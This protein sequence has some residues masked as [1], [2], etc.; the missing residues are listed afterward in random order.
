MGAISGIRGKTYIRRRVIKTSAGIT[1]E[2]LNAC[3]N[4]AKKS[5]T[6]L[7]KVVIKY[8]V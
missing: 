4:V 3:T 6:L 7:T 1:D 2:K 5:P 8:L